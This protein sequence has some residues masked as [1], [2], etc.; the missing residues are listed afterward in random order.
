LD[1]ETEQEG[2][3]RPATGSSES[4]FGLVTDPNKELEAA[5]FRIVD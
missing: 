1:L 5:E 3:E 4:E 2:M